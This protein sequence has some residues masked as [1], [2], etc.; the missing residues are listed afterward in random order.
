VSREDAGRKSIGSGAGNLGIPD[1]QRVW[2]ELAGLPTIR[3]ATGAKV[4]RGIE[5]NIPLKEN[6]AILISKTENSGFV[7]GI[8][9]TRR[10]GFY[11]YQCPAIYYLRIDP[12]YRRGNAFDYPWDQPK[13]IMNAKRKSRS[14]WRIAAVA[15]NAGLVCYQTFTCLWPSDNWTAKSLA[16]VLNGPVANAFVAARE[17]NRDIT[18]ETV[19]EIPVPALT[20]GTIKE[21]DSLVAEYVAS[22]ERSVY[23]SQQVDSQGRPRAILTKIDMLLLAEYDLSAESERSLLQYFNGYGNKRPVPFNFGDYTIRAAPHA[24]RPVESSAEVE[25]ESESW[26]WLRKSL[27]EDRLSSRKL[28]P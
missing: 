6:R 17:G 21:I 20:P 16:A 19:K 27:D 9:S 1:L 2:E 12:E 3:N 10:S 14:P 8:P 4:H 23:D 24:T 18:V 15:D 13:V 26:E 7:P 25:P 22:V 5:W 11:S 28:F